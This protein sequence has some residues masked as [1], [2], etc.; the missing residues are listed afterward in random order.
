MAEEL[1]KYL[2]Q[3]NIKVCYIYS[4]VDMMEWVE[5][6]CD[7][8]LGEFDVFVGVNFLWE[9][10]DLLE[11]FFVVIIDVDKEGFLCNNCFLIQIV[12]WVV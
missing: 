2:Q 6:L 12:G 7:F 4:E 1:I 8:C 11:V 3:M 10:F 5:I 9:G